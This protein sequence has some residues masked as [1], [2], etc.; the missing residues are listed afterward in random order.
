VSKY[1]ISTLKSISVV[2][3]KMHTFTTF[4]RKKAEASRI[5]FNLAIAVVYK[6]PAVDLRN[7]KK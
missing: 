1:Q 2:Y 4:F 6:E 3:T 5:G 7:V